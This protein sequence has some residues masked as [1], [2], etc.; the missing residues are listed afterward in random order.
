MDRIA[1]TDMVVGKR[2]RIRLNDCCV[3]GS[4]F[5]VFQRWDRVDAGDDSY[6]E[7]VFDIGV[8]KP[9]WGQWSVEE[10][11]EDKDA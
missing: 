1:K 5:G 11:G 7:A 6:D 4:F 10:P 8:I 3:E 2:Y 9:R